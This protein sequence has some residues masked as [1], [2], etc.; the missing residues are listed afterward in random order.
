M[1][2][3]AASVP[4]VAM[5]TWQ[6]LKERANL[7][8]G[9]RV[10]VHP[11]GRQ[12]AEIGKL[13]ESG[14]IRPVIDKV[15]PFE[16]LREALASLEKGP[17]DARFGHRPVVGSTR[18]LLFWASKCRRSPTLHAVHSRNRSRGFRCNAAELKVSSASHCP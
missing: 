11:D 13:L 15:F 12:L 17:R 1:K 14:S 16:Q 10:L 18:K 2:A 6:A 3:Q 7:K 4:M 5:T 9:Q 8:P